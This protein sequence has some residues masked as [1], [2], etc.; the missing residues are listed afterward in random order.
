MK[1]GRPMPNDNGDMFVVV[2]A[3]YLQ[4]DVRHVLGRPDDTTESTTALF[5]SATHY[6][7]L[8]VRRQSNAAEDI[9][10][11]IPGQ[12]NNTILLLSFISH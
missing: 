11:H 12:Q 6:H 9:L 8:Q 1:F 7:Y 10:S 4:S 2:A 5:H 3:V